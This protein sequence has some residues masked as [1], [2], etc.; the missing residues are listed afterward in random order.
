M[1]SLNKIQLLIS[2]IIIM[3]IGISYSVYDDNINSFFVKQKS[4]NDYILDFYELA[5]NHNYQE[6]STNETLTF[7]GLGQKYPYNVRYFMVDTDFLNYWY[8]TYNKCVLNSCGKCTNYDNTYGIY[9][10]N[11]DLDKIFINYDMFENILNNDTR[12][13]K[14]QNTL[15]HEITHYL[16]KKGRLYAT[17]KGYIFG[18]GLEFGD[19]IGYNLKTKF[20]TAFE[21]STFEFENP[22]IVKSINMT[23]LFDNTNCWY[24]YQDWG[25]EVVARSWAYCLE[26]Q[27]DKKNINTFK[28]KENNFCSSLGFS[29][30][31]NE[32]NTNWNALDD[33][34][35]FNEFVSDFIESYSETYLLNSSKPYI[36]DLD[37][38][39]RKNLN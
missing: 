20:L 18:E 28:F 39:W 14:L 21:N 25:N 37:N 30:N 31:L 6:N 22:D 5:I 10:S 15:I 16:H 35:V 29:N 19:Y 26:L 9:D 4:Y 13:E 32:S 8:G 7:I 3:G 17:Q 2:I 27:T 33:L 34:E 38:D 23:R 12:Y 24:G 1:K 36:L 11:N